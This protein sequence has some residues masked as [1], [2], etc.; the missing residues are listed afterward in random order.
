[1]EPRK[2]EKPA[3]IFDMSPEDLVLWSAATGMDEWKGS[4]AKAEQ[5]R[6]LT[7][8]L[9]DFN[10]ASTWLGWIMIGMAVIQIFVAVFKK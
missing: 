1:M 5:A 6:R 9:Q 2:I 10:R 8:A 7:K 3:D 4:L